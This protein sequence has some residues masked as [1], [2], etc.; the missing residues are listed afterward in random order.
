MEF[1]CIE[2]EQVQSCGS[3]SQQSLWQCMQRPC[4]ERLTRT[5]MGVQGTDN[6]TRRVTSTDVIGANVFNSENAESNQLLSE[7]LELST[8]NIRSDVIILIVI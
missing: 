6:G 7:L 2:K 8:G 4:V 3:V 1:A 5:C